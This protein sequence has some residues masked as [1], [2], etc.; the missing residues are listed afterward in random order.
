MSAAK[1]THIEPKLSRFDLTMIIVSLVIGVGIFR[2]PNVVAQKAGTPEIFF[3]A[4]IFGGIISICGALTFAEI[5][6]RFP[7]A[8]GFYKIFSHCYHPAFAFM[9]NWIQVIINASSGVGVA[10]IGAEYI[11]P[12]ILPNSL[13]NEAGI[14]I[15]VL[16]T[17]I[18][19]YAINYLGIRIGAGTQNILSMAKIAL[20][21]AFCLTIFG[22]PAVQEPIAVTASPVN[23][24]LVSAFGISL[25]S[26]FFS[27]GGYQQTMNFGG[28]IKHPDRNIPLA[29][30]YGMGIVITL[31]LCVN[32]ALYRVLGFEHIQQSKV[33]FADLAGTFLGKMG[34]NFTSVVIF[35]SVLGFINT[36]IMSNPRIYYAMAEDKVLPKIFQ[37]VNPKT[38]IQEF[39]LT[40][41]IAMMIAALFFFGTFEKVVNYVMFADSIAFAAAAASVFIL[42]KKKENESVAF[43]NSGFPVIP[44]L[45]IVTL[46]GVSAS[47]MI[48]DYSA[49]VYGFILFLSGLPIYYLM[50]RA[51]ERK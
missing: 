11:N 5:G 47:V 42:R 28:D 15:T 14:K 16:T 2:L 21:V 40:F 19:F 34:A 22:K 10:I 25:I 8:G 18:A 27:Y 38:Q 1:S 9:L 45:F 30:F 3:A 20:V 23:M 48:D 50:K 51:N 44:L 13:Q 24:S 12:L 43:K 37:R 35:I 26:V 33:L 31:Y 4:W 17:L 6:S 41:Y 39:S 49:S 32:Y 36:S 29:I 46:L 7:A